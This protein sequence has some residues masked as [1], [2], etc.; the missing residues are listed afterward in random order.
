[1]LNH[2]KNYLCLFAHQIVEAQNPDGFTCYVEPGSGVEGT[3]STS[4]SYNGLLHTPD[5]T[6]RLLIVYGGFGG[7]EGNY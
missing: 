7:F 6:L 1:M 3:T 5:G 2:E 4:K